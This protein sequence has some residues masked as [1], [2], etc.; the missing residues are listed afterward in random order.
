MRG[1]GLIGGD[2]PELSVGKGYVGVTGV[3]YLY[4]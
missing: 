2:G 4:M 1:I 3:F